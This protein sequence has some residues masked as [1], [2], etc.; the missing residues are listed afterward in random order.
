VTRQAKTIYNE[1]QKLATRARRIIYLVNSKSDGPPARRDRHRVGQ[2][3]WTVLEPV[4]RSRKA[5]VRK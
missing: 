5:A 3:L 1:L 2:L 4:E